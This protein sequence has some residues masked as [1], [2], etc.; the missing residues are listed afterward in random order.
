MS[1]VRGTR[2]SALS[3]AIAM[4]AGAAM[5]G[6]GATGAPSGTATNA[7]GP[8]KSAFEFSRCMR[9]NGAPNF[10]DPGPNGFPQSL[11][12][13][14]P[15]VERAMNACQKY[16]PPSGPAPTTPESV[17]LQEIALAKCMR[18]NGVPHFPDPNAS[19][20]I[21]FPVG[22]PML[23]TPAFQHAQNG[24]CKKYQLNRP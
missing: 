9:A 23:K 20:N 19:G 8:S 18:A 2:V 13:S 24:P 22:D 21:Q 15:A 5:P 4:L 6:C 11:N 17:R 1:T 10:P 3:I 12:L 14:A 16:L 7:S